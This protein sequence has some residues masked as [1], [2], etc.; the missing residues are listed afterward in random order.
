MSLHQA[1]VAIDVQIKIRDRYGALAQQIGR[2]TVLSS[3]Q[4]THREGGLSHADQV[5]SE[6]QFT[7]IRG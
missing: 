6:Q 4:E 1:Q 3:E 5:M 7:P 2:D